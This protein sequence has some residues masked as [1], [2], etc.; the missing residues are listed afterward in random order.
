MPC[1]QGCTS[2]KGVGVAVAGSPRAALQRCALTETQRERGG[3]ELI[4][5]SCPSGRESPQGSC[6]IESRVAVQPAKRGKARPG[7][8][9]HR[10]RRFP[11]LGFCSW[12]AKKIRSAIAKLQDIG[13]ERVS[14]TDFERPSHSSTHSLLP[15]ALNPARTSLSTACKTLRQCRPTMQQPLIRR[16]P[17]ASPVSVRRQFSSST[18]RRQDDN[19]DESAVEGQGSERP[20]WTY[21]PERL[22]GPF[23]INQPKKESRTVWSV[24]EKPELLDAMYKRLLGHNG[25]KMLPDEIKWLA[26]THKSFDYGRRGFNTRLA[27]YGTVGSFSPQAE[28]CARC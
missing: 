9:H 6:S 28:Q 3:R 1:H 23:R 10:S 14:A 8:V 24:N 17:G 2:V 15:M 11:G 19:L 21:T 7:S 4:G 27:Y 20:R 18:P 22:K 5:Q 12:L 16:L 13:R 26:V 25:D